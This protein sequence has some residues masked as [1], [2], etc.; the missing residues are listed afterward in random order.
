MLLI[1]LHSCGVIVLGYSLSCSQHGSGTP[2][3][4]TESSGVESAMLNGFFHFRPN[5][6]QFLAVV[7]YTRWVCRTSHR[8]GKQKPTGLPDF[9]GSAIS[10]PSPPVAC[11]GVCGL[12]ARH[13]RLEPVLAYQTKVPPRL[14]STRWSGSQSFPRHCMPPKPI[15]AGPARPAPPWLTPAA[16]HNDSQQLT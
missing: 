11:R 3:L 14:V 10:P 5:L 9:G 2:R 4:A 6:R 12:T 7:G 13:F 1:F 15:T 16:T 8:C